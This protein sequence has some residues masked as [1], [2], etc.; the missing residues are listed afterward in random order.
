MT[1]TPTRS[2]PGVRHRAGTVRVLTALVL[3]VLAVAASLV[4]I[5]VGTKGLPLIDVVRLLLDPS[6]SVPDPDAAYIVHDLRLPRTAVAL[7]VGAALAVA[8]ALVQALTRNPLADTGILGVDAGAALAV[9]LGVAW[10]SIHGIAGYAWCA[11][12]G[13]LVTTVAVYL[14]GGRLGADPMRLVL[15]GLALGAVISGITG[16]LTLSNP[17]TFD[18]MRHWLVGSL[19][20]RDLAHI[21]PLLPHLAIGLAVAV[22][23]TPSLNAIALGDDLAASHGVKVLRVRILVI[24]AITLLAGTATAVCGPIGF[25]GLMVP[26][27]VRWIVGPDQRWVVPLSAIAGATMLVLSDVLGR[28]IVAPAEMPAGVVTAFVGAPV[29]IILIRGRRRVSGL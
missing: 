16:M 6:A 12:A 2:S 19:E 29:L 18:S 17:D 8:G 27:V 4:S 5:A 13:A 22:A 28:V 21:V 15:A 20:N 1:L 25:V 10:F 23:V 26:H 3:L 11:Y 24:S 7:A 9:T 14:I